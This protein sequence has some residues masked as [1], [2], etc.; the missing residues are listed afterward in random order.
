MK[1]C[2]NRNQV[3]HKIAWGFGGGFL[4]IY[5]SLESAY[6]SPFLTNIG[7]SPQIKKRGYY[8]QFFKLKQGQNLSI[9]A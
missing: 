5:L 7:L 6:N 4:S 2:Y 1:S 9:R 3:D 8:N